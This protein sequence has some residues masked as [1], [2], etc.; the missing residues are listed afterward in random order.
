M[1]ATT[2]YDYLN[3]FR[4]YY[5]VYIVSSACYDVFKWFET[6]LFILLEIQ[7]I[8]NLLKVA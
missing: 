3:G 1:A 2:F 8:L 7:E 6:F 4:I 5:D